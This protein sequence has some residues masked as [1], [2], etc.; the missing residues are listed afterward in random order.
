[1]EIYE[2]FHSDSIAKLT[3]EFVES[4]VLRAVGWLLALVHLRTWV[5]GSTLLVRVPAKLP[6]TVNITTN[7]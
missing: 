4:L 5:G 3:N 6:V 7:A 1:M 2:Q